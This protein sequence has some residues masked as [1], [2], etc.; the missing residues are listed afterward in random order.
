MFNVEQQDDGGQVNARAFYHRF[1]WAYDLLVERPGGP[2]VESVV[3]IFESEGLERGSALVDAGCGTAAYAIELASY[4]FAVTAVDRSPE[5]LAEAQ[6]R[7]NKCA[8]EVEF[9]C[10]DFTRGWQPRDLVDG[11]LCR[12][13][14]NDLLGD[15]ARE[16]A[17]RAFAAWLR[18][19]G[20]L[21]ADVRDCDSSAR[22]Y[23]GGRTFERTVRRGD[24]ILTF[25][26][27]TTVEPGSDVLRLIERWS[28]AVDGVPVEQEDR[29]AMRCW[30]RES[31]AALAHAVGFG[32]VSILDPGAIGARSDRLVAIAYR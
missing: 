28:G 20:V 9:A 3:G 27:R 11:V 18:P 16:R 22:R 4:G 7:A 15:D 14:L 25:T 19:D 21:L 26:S 24:D 5:L 30:T 8:V 13:V 23:D 32:R 1:A 2:D 31:F 12:G 10:A 29:F 17:F 6:V